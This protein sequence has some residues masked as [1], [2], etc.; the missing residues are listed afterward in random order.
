M[1]KITIVLSTLAIVA[2]LSSCKKDTT[3]PTPPANNP[4]TVT[5]PSDAFGALLS[6]DL[7]TS[8]TT[9]AYPGVPSLNVDYNIGTASAIFTISAGATTFQ[10]AGTV[11]CNDST[12]TKA[13]NNGYIFSPNA[14]AAGS[15]I[16][17]DNS[18]SQ[19]NWSVSGSAAVTSFNFSHTGTLPTIGSITSATSIPTN[20]AYTLAVSSTS[21]NADSI[22]WIMAGPNK[23]VQHVT[24]PGVTSSTFTAAEVASLGTGDNLGLL[25]VAPYRIVPFTKNGKQY[26]FVKERCVTKSVSLK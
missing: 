20:A 14:V 24:A 12:L 17:L 15:N 3:T 5:T 7:L 2:S 1:K 19:F 18:V 21:F 25:Q 10:D 9:P 22:I 6:I 11:I 16:G 13:S 26:Y 8:F 23:N 4:P